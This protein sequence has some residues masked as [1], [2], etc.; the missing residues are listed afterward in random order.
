[1]KKI[2]AIVLSAAICFA[3]S[4]SLAAV[5]KAG[6]K[7]VSAGKTLTVGSNKLSCVVT[8]GKKTWKKIPN[9]PLAY[10]PKGWDGD[11]CGF[12]SGAT[13]YAAKLQDFLLNSGYCIGSLRLV[14]GNLP[15]ALPRTADSPTSALAPIDKCKLQ[16]A[17]NS[18]NWKGF[19]SSS[20]V[21]DFKKNRHPSP[22]TVLQIIPIFASDVPRSGNTPE[23]DYKYYFDFLRDYFKYINDGPG[24]LEL[25]VPDSYIEF[26][27]PI[28]PYEVRHGKDD[29]LARSFF[30][31]VITSVDSKFNFSEINYALVVVPA[32][33]PSGVISQQGVGHVSTAEGD[34]TNISSAQPATLSGPNNKVNVTMMKPTMWI[35]E[36][37]HPGLNLGD[38]HAGDSGL[39]DSERGM[40]DWG[41]MSRDNGDLIAWQKWI[42]G[43]LQ[44]SQVR[45]ID[46]S[47]GV[48]LSWIAPSS[49]K[50][51]NSKLVVIP[52]T[53]QKA[54]VV[55][56]IRA[57]GL[58][59]R[60]ST[61]SLGALV[62]LVDESDAR[63]DYGYA[64]M[65]PDNR[66][67]TV[68]RFKLSDAPLKL[69]ESLT[70]EGIKITNVEWGDFGDVIKVE[71]VK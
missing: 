18:N 22:S 29:D 70:Y 11:R 21:T 48:T 50:T 34:L 55:E 25:R 52:L 37:Y 47:T 3:V 54:L 43:F 69:G 7:C 61:E 63:H 24:N 40:G 15:S 49:I 4:P 57:V 20:E 58:S 31:D 56:S 60:Y 16:N 39:Y 66:R 68:S 9:Q 38:N 17:S 42:L 36:F 62:Y 35:H 8:G 5:P 10:K 46:V 12:D 26:P 2:I 6:S 13:G 28:A 45:C 67:P 65:Y 53:S 44:D 19:P 71:P 64:A 27:K 23:Q 30:Q 32:G 1:M 59:Y 51:T 41:I 33:T 14:A